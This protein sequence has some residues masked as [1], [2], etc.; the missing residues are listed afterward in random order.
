MYLISIFYTLLSI[1]LFI[2]YILLST[3]IYMYIYI[4]YLLLYQTALSIHSKLIQCGDTITR[5]ALFSTVNSLTSV[6]IKSVKLNY[7]IGKFLYSALTNGTQIHNSIDCLYQPYVCYQAYRYRNS[8]ILEK[9]GKFYTNGITIEA[10]RIFQSE[11]TTSIHIL[12]TTR[13]SLTDHSQTL[14]YILQ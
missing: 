13:I 4:S 5:I 2:I 3:C 8:F 6:S 14:L 12:P 11:H 10:P 1:S 7:P 9:V